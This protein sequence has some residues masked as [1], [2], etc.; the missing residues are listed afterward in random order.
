[1]T[2]RD[3][4]ILNEIRRVWAEELHQSGPL[5]L[6]ADLI[7]D[8]QL[9]SLSLL[10]LVVSLEDRFQLALREQDAPGIQ[11]V[12]DLVALV[13]RRLAEGRTA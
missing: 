10:T 4:E 6:D 3:A 9:D 12:G 5:E 8:L 13:A 11:T 2:A 1:M 7:T